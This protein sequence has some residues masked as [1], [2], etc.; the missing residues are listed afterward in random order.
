ML[1]AFKDESRS[2]YRRI[3]NDQGAQ[4]IVLSCTAIEMLIGAEGLGATGV[5]DHPASRRV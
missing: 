2:G 4:G 3:I 5:L 1:G